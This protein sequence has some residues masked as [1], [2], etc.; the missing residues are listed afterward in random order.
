MPA[1]PFLVLLAGLPL[2]LMICRTFDQLVFLLRTQHTAQWES[3]G[4]PHPFIFKAG[5]SWS[6]ALRSSFATQRCALF[7]LFATPQWL[8]T[9]PA[10]LRHL[11]RLRVLAAVWNLAFMPF[12]AV[13]AY[14]S[15][16]AR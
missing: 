12:Y 4:K 6:H 11:R 9:D 2:L 10:A 3:D 5:L 15:T 8:G 1:L 13:V 7:W 14:L 16:R